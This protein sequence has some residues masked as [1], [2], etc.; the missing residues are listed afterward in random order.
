MA[1]DREARLLDRGEQRLVARVPVVGEAQ[2]GGEDRQLQGLAAALGRPLHFGDRVFDVVDRNLVRDDQPLRIFRREL[3]ERGVERARRLLAAVADEV[4]VAEG[5]DL[6]I[7]DGR[8]DAVA[9]HV[10]EPCLRVAVTGGV[11]HDVTAAGSH[12]DG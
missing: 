9:V 8:L 10:G 1:A 11:E 2:L 5:R 7:G 3:G 12:S 4:Q 6:A